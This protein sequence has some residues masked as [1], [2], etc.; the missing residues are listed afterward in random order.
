VEAIIRH[1]HEHYDG[2]GYP[3]GIKGRNI[4]LGSRIIAIADSFVAM[5]TDRPYRRALPEV[6]AIN[7]IMKLVG[8]QFDPEVVEVFFA[9]L[10]QQ[11]VLEGAKKVL[12]VIESDESVAAYLR[13]N[14]SCDAYELVL[15]DNTAE[16]YRFIDER[17]PSL[18]ISEHQLLKNDNLSFYTAA[19]RQS[20]PFIVFVEKADLPKL[21]PD[22]LVD[23][24]SRPF[25]IEAL[26]VKIRVCLMND[27]VAARTNLS[28]EPLRGVSGSLEDM[29]LTDIIQVLSMG[30]KTAK[31]LI[32]NDNVKGEIYLKNGK[33]VYVE[34]ED[35]TGREAFYK[36]IEWERGEFRVFHGQATDKVNVTVETMTLLLEASKTMDEKRYAS[37]GGV[38][39]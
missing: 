10:R 30:M 22:Q 14:L 12:L 24:V 17:T 6:A 9:V 20:I 38:N 8:S 18:V 26:A 7:E 1:H 37:V 36:M 28:D 34:L 27:T 13:L 29:G 32:S 5:T 25:D 15:V 16:A 3:D 21:H 11:N 39:A 35:L 23:F 19:R 4:P 33:I 31:V 2:N